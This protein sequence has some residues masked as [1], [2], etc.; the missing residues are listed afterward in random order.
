MSMYR[1]RRGRKE[2]RTRWPWRWLFPLKLDQRYC[3][4]CGQSYHEG[5]HPEAVRGFRQGNV[6]ALVFPGGGYRSNSPYAVR[7]GR[8]KQVTRSFLFSEYIPSDEL[9]DLKKVF[10]EVVAYFDEQRETKTARR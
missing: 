5:P 9:D 2:W 3:R 7:L 10:A 4:H 1:V 8:W 6:G